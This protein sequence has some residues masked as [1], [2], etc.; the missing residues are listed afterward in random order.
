MVVTLNMFMIF[1][2]CKQV[3]QPLPREQ[4]LFLGDYREVE[5][6]M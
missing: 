3:K 6:D 5:M 1:Y 4:A 2:T